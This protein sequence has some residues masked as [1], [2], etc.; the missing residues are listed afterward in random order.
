MKSKKEQETDVSVAIP[1]EENEPTPAAATAEPATAGEATPLPLG[2]AWENFLASLAPG[3]KEALLSVLTRLAA[4]EAARR[5]EEEEA[6]CLTEMEGMPAFAGISARRGEIDDLIARIGWLR[7]LP[8]RDRLAAACYLDRGMRLHEPTR[9]EKLEAVLSDPALLRALAEKQA[10]A[11]AAKRGALAPTAH[12]GGRMPAN[13]PKP[14]KDLGEAGL[15][16]KQY[17][18]IHKNA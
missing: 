9:E 14:P 7:A 16:A 15:A 1:T 11:R 6:A 2:A 10:M 5:E 4:R 8:M 12:A 17:F 18:Q 3:D 13:L